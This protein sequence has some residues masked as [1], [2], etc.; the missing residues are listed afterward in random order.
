MARIL[1]SS[2]RKFVRGREKPNAMMA[3]ICR[4]LVG[5]MKSGVAPTLMVL[6]MVR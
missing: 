5:E 2:C 1:T 6:R 3:R 4:E